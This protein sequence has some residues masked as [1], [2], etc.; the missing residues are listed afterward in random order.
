M[1]SFLSVVGKK[2]LH[3][4]GV[5]ERGHLPCTPLLRVVGKA[6]FS[7]SFPL[8]GGDAGRLPKFR[9]K[10]YYTRTCFKLKRTKGLDQMR[11]SSGLLNLIEHVQRI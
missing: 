9:V 4:R 11:K 7:R 3:G 8:N 10:Y 6:Q 2:T 1:H 5:L